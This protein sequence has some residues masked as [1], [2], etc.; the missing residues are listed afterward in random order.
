MRKQ[1]TLDGEG[2]G[3]ISDILT[4]VSDAADTSDLV[5]TDIASALDVAADT[6]YSLTPGT[7]APAGPS[8]PAS[9]PVPSLSASL[10]ANSPKLLIAGV[11]LLAVSFLVL[12][13]K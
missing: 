5:P 3:D 6:A 8:K 2:F 7:A 4:T 9:I 10:K 1:E 11:A 13:K 12:R